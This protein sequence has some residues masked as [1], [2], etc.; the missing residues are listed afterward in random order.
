LSVVAAIVQ[1][2]G[3]GLSATFDHND[4]HHLV[5]AVALYGFYRAGRLF[6]QT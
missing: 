4:L 5:Q 3:R 1:M 2:E 6:A